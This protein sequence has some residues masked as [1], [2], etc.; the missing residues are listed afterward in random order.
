M[1]PGEI[2][3]GSE[4]DRDIEDSADVVVVGS[5]A[6]GAVVAA[7]LAEAGQSVVVLEEGPH[8]PQE[9]YGR[10]RPSE[11]LRHLW[12]DGGL[13]MA[14]GLG[15]TP[16]INVMMGECVGGSSVLTGG[17][18][19][20]TP[21]AVLR[22]WAERFGLEELDEACM[23]PYFDDVERSV[24]VEEVPEAMRSLST[25]M[26]ARGAERCGRPVRPLRRNT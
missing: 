21:G 24:H 7:H 19:F 1:T 11:T 22:E 5:G 16:V 13:T 20:R 8:V 12:R 15:N 23:E 25:V 3:E 18:C 14:M 2:I 17:V 26:F 9:R 4:L 10:M 6:G